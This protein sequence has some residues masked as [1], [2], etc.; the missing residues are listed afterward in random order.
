MRTHLTHALLTLW[1]LVFAG[2][3]AVQL[4]DT[5]LGNSL[6]AATIWMGFY[7]L[8]HA[9]GLAT[10]RY[11]AMLGLFVPT[12]WAMSLPSLPSGLA[13]RCPHGRR[14]RAGSDWG[15]SATLDGG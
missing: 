8:A 6:L 7:P 15:W 14:A 12:V 13:R 1:A 9:V 2:A 10:S 4:P 11:W 3:I 5:A